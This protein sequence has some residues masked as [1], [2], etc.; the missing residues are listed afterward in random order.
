MN[1]LNGE[2]KVQESALVSLNYANAGIYDAIK[3]T[4]T[5][6]FTCIHYGWS[7]VCSVMSKS[8]TKMSLLTGTP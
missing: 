5:T 8:S 3:L 4:A 7:V 2:V 6:N 1:I